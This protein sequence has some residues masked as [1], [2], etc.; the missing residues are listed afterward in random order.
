M[1]FLIV[2]PLIL[3]ILASILGLKTVDW[4]TE[5]KLT[6]FYLPIIG[7]IFALVMLFFNMFDIEII[8]ISFILLEI[9]CSSVLE[10]GAR[11]NIISAIIFLFCYLGYIGSK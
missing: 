8:F 6:S 4:S 5:E 3:R 1:E 11:I 10:K 9:I 7:G 2:V